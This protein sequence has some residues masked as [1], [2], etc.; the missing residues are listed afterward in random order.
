MTPT[1]AHT[2]GRPLVAVA[3][4]PSPLL[5]AALDRALDGGPALLPVAPDLPDAARDRLLSALRPAALVD[6]HGT[7]PL[8]AAAP[9][10]DDVALVVATSGSTG[11][12]KGVA[13]TAAA[14]LASARAGLARLGADGPDA[15]RWLACLP[16]QHI[17]GLLVL[18]RGR[19]TGVAPVLHARFDTAAV[20]AV[21][22]GGQADHVALV[23]TMLRRL[24]DAGAPLERFRTV[25]L[26]GAAAPAPL[27]AE[28]RAAG[29]RVV[30][31][32]GMTE[33][34][35]GCVWDGLP[36]DGVDADVDGDGRVRL[37]G[38]VLCAGYR[39]GAAVR[40]VVDADGWFRTA[41]LGRWDGVRL[42]VLGR[43]DD[44]VVTGGENIA[45]GAVA[46]LLLEHP[47]VADAAVV[48][49]P[50]TQ[51]GERL[52]AVVVPTDPSAPPTLAALRTHVAAR[53]GR[54]AAPRALEVVA[55]LPLLPG[56]KVDRLA[57]RAGT[58]T[59]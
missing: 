55:A 14:V 40:P 24:L 3:A 28:A 46:A 26:G 38:P 34:A 7:T 39:Q 35:G 30:T 21:A 29:A 20:A 41:D 31:T 4:G 9:V 27:L 52:V 11:A 50:D 59:G 6:G 13:L 15:G 17:G 45:A 43:A 22:A 51:W 44:V 23:P 16:A 33:T 8:D 36:L 54:A 37:R 2:G 57:L 12:P 5:A 53:A 49:R 56:G 1:S 32:Y 42:V 48:G 18:V 25:L 58:A 10:P 47:A 19:L